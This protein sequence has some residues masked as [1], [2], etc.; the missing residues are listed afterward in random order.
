MQH[1]LKPPTR[2]AWAQ[3]VAGVPG[4]GRGVGMIYT[5]MCYTQI[6]QSISAPIPPGAPEGLWVGWHGG[7]VLPLQPLGDDQIGERSSQVALTLGDAIELGEV[8]N[9]KRNNYCTTTPLRRWKRLST[10][11]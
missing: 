1:R 11:T 2:A 10:G 8:G 3:V 5:V 4:I 6:P 9:R 7:L